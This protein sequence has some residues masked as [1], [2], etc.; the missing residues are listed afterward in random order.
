MNSHKDNN[1]K[2]CVHQLWVHIFFTHYDTD[3]SYFIHKMG[4][5]G[6]PPPTPKARYFWGLGVHTDSASV[7]QL[8]MWDLPIAWEWTTLTTAIEL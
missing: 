8:T 2:A 6:N 5:Q 3:L 1:W 4:I 7:Q